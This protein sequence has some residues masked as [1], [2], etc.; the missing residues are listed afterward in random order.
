GPA[1]VELLICVPGRSG[2]DPQT[3]TCRRG[4]LRALGAI[5]D[6]RALHAVLDGLDAGD[7]R[8]RVTAAQALGELGPER[9]S[10]TV[11]SRLAAL[12]E[13]AAPELRAAVVEAMGKLGGTAAL[14]AATRALADGQ[15]EVAQAG[16]ASLAAAVRGGTAGALDLLQ[17]ALSSPEPALRSR[18]ASELGRLGSLAMAA[19]DALVERLSDPVPVVSQA[20]EEALGRLGWRPVGWRTRR[21]DK[22]YVYW[23]RRSEWL[24][25]DPAASQR[26]L[27]VAALSEEDADRR[28]NAAE[29]LGLLRDPAA[30]PALRRLLDDP[31]FDVQVVAAEALTMLGEQPRDEPGWA[32]WLAVRGRWDA[33]AALGPA[34]LPGLEEVL[35]RGPESCRLPALRTLGR[36]GGAPTVPILLAVL[37]LDDPEAGKLAA[38]QLGALQ[39]SEA[40]PALVALLADE[41]YQPEVAL[42]LALLGKPALAA[43]TSVLGDETAEP[44]A[45]RWAACALGRSGLEKALAPLT[46]QLA[47]DA[48][49]LRAAAAS[50]LGTLGLARATEPL[51]ELL[52]S[53][54]Q[55]MVRLA[56]AQALGLLQQKSSVKALQRGLADG[57][58]EVR[59]ACITALEALGEPP[60][61][62]LLE[63]SRMIAA[64]EWAR[65]A[66]LG[67]PAVEPLLVVLGERELDPRTQH[68]CAGAAFALGR[69]GD[70]RAVAALIE[71]LSL[72]SSEVQR[73]AAEAL[74]LLGKPEAGPAVAALLPSPAAVVR[75]AAIDSLARIGV[76]PWLEQVA[77]A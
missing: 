57:Y 28:R 1:A 3:S 69:I 67:P 13:D 18:A 59:R 17:Q 38:E 58:G 31:V 34:A 29:G 68:R 76:R 72:P 73:A 24:K 5:D 16:L 70:Q 53:D 50:A 19:I 11:R 71:A 42:A 46:R 20:A 33:L 64:E 62:E 35:L 49:Y 9:A 32:A 26:E 55:W 27:L 75:A 77:R 37:K 66:A 22:G 43:L 65:C 56:A 7:L 47:S 60:S 8:L 2:F 21:T 10:P 41:R 15:P 63:A 6:P 48:T 39:A 61:A 45:R 25:D 12:L 30:V 51:G 52:R 74:G 44:T 54:A 36:I 23:T 14:D 40:A 4:A